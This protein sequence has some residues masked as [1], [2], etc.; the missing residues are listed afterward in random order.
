MRKTFFGIL[1]CLTT[2]AFA[3][4]V[5]RL[6]SLGF[7]ADGKNFAFMEGGTHDGLGNSYANIK[8]IEVAT[9]KYAAPVLSHVQT[10]EDI[11]SDSPKTLA[12]IEQEAISKA[13]ETLKKLGITR[14]IPGSI[15]ASRKLSDIEASKLK[16][17]T[18]SVGDILHLEAAPQYKLNLSISNAV[19][20]QGVYCVS[21]TSNATKK[22]KLTLTNLISKKTVTL[23]EDK[24]LPSSRGCANNYVIEDV[25]VKNQDELNSD[26]GSVV[27]LIRITSEQHGG[28]SI[29]YMAVSGNLN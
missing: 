20:P 9:N 18:F 21:E 25:I 15:R 28:N 19:K 22:L 6:T 3:G 5:A 7:S 23:Q 1:L 24:A 29:R 27:V 17:V 4:D 12:Q 16:T 10:E 13:D 2:S 14:S 26:V 8:F 11:S